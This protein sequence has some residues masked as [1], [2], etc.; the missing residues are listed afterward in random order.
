M[1]YLMDKLLDAKFNRRQ[2]LKGSATA[3]AAVVG[4]GL[5]GCAKE[6]SLSES[7]AAPEDTTAAETAPG[8]ATADHS[9]IENP[10]A[11]GT[12]VAAACW[13]NCAGRCVNKVMVKDGMVI[14]QKTDDSHEDSWEHMQQRS[15]VR[16]RSQQQQCFGA[17]RLKYPMK[18]KNWQPGGGEGT[19][20]ELR[21]KDEWER[22]SWEEA[23][24]LVASEIKRIYDTYG[25]GCCMARTGDCAK[26]ILALLGGY[27][28][29]ADTTSY[30]TYCFNVD[31][32]GLPAYGL[33]S[34]NDR[35]DLKNSETIV[36]Y[37]CNPAWASAGSRTWNFMHNKKNGKTQFIVVGPSYNA[38]AATFEA[39]W[40]RV[41]PGTDTAFLLGVAYEMLALDEA[42]GGIIDWDFL[43]KYT[44]GF[45]ADHMPEG[46]KLNENFKDYVLGAYDDTPKDAEWASNIC[47]T[48]VEDIRWYA[49]EMRKD[50]AV[51]ILHSYAHARNKNAEDIPQLF[52]T[53]GCMGGH[54]GKPGHSCGAAYGTDAGNCGPA[55]V[56]VG[57]AGLPPAPANE[58]DLRLN[59][60]TMWQ[61]ILTGKANNNAD[62]YA[63]RY[64]A[65]DIRDVNVKMMYWDGDARL[66][67][68]PDLVNGIKVM[69]Q[70]E[71]VC[72]NAQFLTTQARYSDIVLPVTTMWERIGGFSPYSNRESLFVYSQVTEPLYEAK[73]DVDIC[74]G[75]LEA[76]GMGEKADE[77]WPIS[78][79]QQFFNQLA[80]CKV[81]NADGTD[82]V[83]LL[84]ITQADIDERGVEGTPQEG[85]VD[86]KTFIE[87]G[88][89]TVPRKEGDPYG[90]ISYQ[91]FIE[92]PENNP[93]PSASGKFEIYNDWKADTLN[94]MGYSPD[95]T[96]K[97]YPTYTV[98]P[99]GYETTFKDGIIGGEPGEYPFIVYNPHYLR[100]SHSVFDNCPWLRETWPNPVFLN[101]EDAKA[102]GIKTGDT[103]K[104][105]NAHG[106]ILRT[107][108][109]TGII[110]PGCVGVPH[111]SWIDYDD[112]NQVDRGGADNVL[113]GPVISG[114]GVTGY[115]NYNCNYGLYDG[116]PL[117]PDVE[118][119]QRII[120][121]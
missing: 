115:N 104:V 12:W 41:R 33:G 57:S 81:I 108:S 74:R 114:M 13:H 9:P 83:P 118:K 55:L 14:R 93:R 67:T 59:G 73:D 15:C 111:G 1:A 39:K 4:L 97:P 28:S 10:E 82:Y 31:T 44:V 54:M 78:K 23:F 91:D 56:T 88:C 36:F 47:G 3:T 65:A 79:E 110:M 84:T 22:I 11:G 76:M 121:L 29:Y 32:I 62:Y 105:Y 53:I 30:G 18:R 66:Q 87:D 92:D 119:P 75:I 85:V 69:R 35:M 98:S 95:G 106:A 50:K 49:G 100:R 117:V 42:E 25:P 48:P 38:T 2:F 96:F 61:S 8:T 109:L 37:G 116:E 64:T 68:S 94:S 27:T 5:V 103:V 17:D 112:E 45:D 107:A 43:D 6:A 40:I 58:C 89:Y 16:G 46:A 24:Q 80:G 99:E 90:F 19:H 63:R 20:P 70:L 34:A 120:E 72:T 71:F 60:P 26:H 21:G 86:L 113:C 52:M 101:K 102:K 77:I 7:T 51:S